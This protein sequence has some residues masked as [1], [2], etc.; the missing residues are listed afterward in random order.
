MLEALSFP[1]RDWNFDYLTDDHLTS[2]RSVFS[3]VDR[4]R[5]GNGNGDGDGD[6]DG[7]RDKDGN[8]DKDRDE[9]GSGATTATT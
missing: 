8:K 1:S 2:K 3:S 4:V 7:D 5:N 6:G 9:N